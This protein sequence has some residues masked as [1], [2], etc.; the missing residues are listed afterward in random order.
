MLFRSSR[1]NTSGAYARTPCERMRCGQLGARRRRS[2]RKLCG[3]FDKP[4]AHKL[5]ANRLA[6]WLAASL[7]PRPLGSLP[8]KSI[9]APAQ[10]S[11]ALRGRITY[12]MKLRLLYNAVRLHRML[13]WAQN[14]VWVCE[15]YAETMSTVC[16]NVSSPT[17]A[18]QPP[19]KCM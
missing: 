12:R 18:P 8:H 9:V 19:G 14:G 16:E 13:K 4:V 17:P 10:A 1:F 3:K 5:L 6:V 11:F 15:T 2:M 7:A